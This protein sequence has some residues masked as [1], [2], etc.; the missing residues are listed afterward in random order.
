M[1]VA[2]RVKLLPVIMASP[3]ECWSESQLLQPCV[4]VMH[5]GRE[6]LTAPVLVPL[7]PCQIPGGSSLLWP[8]TAP[9]IVAILGANQEMQGPPLFPIC[10]SPLCHFAFQ[11]IFF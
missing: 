7:P 1:I 3:I 2:L 9:A 11:I 10:P 8:G 6:Q 5:L 4:L